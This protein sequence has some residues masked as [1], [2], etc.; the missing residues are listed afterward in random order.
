MDVGG[1]CC[2]PN[3]PIV[4][5]GSGLDRFIQR[6]QHGFAV[7]EHSG[8]DFLHLAS[9]RT[10]RLGTPDGRELIVVLALSAEGLAKRVLGV[11]DK[12]GGCVRRT[13]RRA[14]SILRENVFADFKHGESALYG[15]RN[16]VWTTQKQ[17]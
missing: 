8:E 4:L 9:N 6:A 17:R 11:D 10:S 5:G 1:V 14:E 2:L 16:A 15:V 7:G 3:R 13:T 12:E